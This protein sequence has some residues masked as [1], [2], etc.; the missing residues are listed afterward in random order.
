MKYTTLVIDPSSIMPLVRIPFIQV[1]TI[2]T[3]LVIFTI[4]SMSWAQNSWSLSQSTKQLQKKVAILV[5]LQVG[6]LTFKCH[7]FR[8]TEGEF[9]IYLKNFTKFQRMLQMFISENNVNQ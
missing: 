7:V 1:I 9:I 3:P 5:Y 6:D 8:T 2:V 4:V